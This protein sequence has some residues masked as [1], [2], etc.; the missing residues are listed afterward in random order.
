MG[1]MLGVPKGAIVNFVVRQVKKMVPAWELPR[2]VGG[3]RRP[4]R[5][6]AQHGFKPVS[7]GAG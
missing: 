5:R 2:A 1:D 4:W 7:V 3:S 6:G